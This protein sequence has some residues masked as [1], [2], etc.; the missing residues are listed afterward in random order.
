[1]TIEKPIPNWLLQP[2]TSGLN[3]EMNQSESRAI[4]ICNFLKAQEKS[5]YKLQ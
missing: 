5:M 2:I 3:S 4:I 1:M